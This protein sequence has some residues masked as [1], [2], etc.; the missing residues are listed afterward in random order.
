MDLFYESAD[1]LGPFLA[2]GVLWCGLVDEDGELPSGVFQRRWNET[3]VSEGWSNIDA[4]CFPDL[5]GEGAE[6][7]WVAGEEGSE[8]VENRLDEGG[9][10]ISGFSGTLGDYQ[11]EAV[12]GEGREG[13]GGDLSDQT[14]VLVGLS[15]NIREGNDGQ[16]L[17]GS[18]IL[19]F[20]CGV[21]GANKWS[22]GRY[23]Q[24]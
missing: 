11:G 22:A 10:D 24:R 20:L 16:P 17:C 5:T 23:L 14:L 2:A 12:G 8:G 21:S 18:W 19:W 13:W 4:R 3:S 15:V 6:D 7:C 9:W 1:A